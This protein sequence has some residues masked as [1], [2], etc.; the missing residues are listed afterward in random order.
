MLYKYNQPQI[1]EEVKMEDY[2][3]LSDIPQEETYG[4]I[5][6]L[7]QAILINETAEGKT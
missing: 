3:K 7:S 5:E 6:D 4:I 1:G 2:P